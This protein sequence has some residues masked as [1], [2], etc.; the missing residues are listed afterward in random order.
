MLAGQ[1]HVS[2]GRFSDDALVSARISLLPGVYRNWLVGTM[3]SFS[4]RYAVQATIGFTSFGLAFQS[5]RDYRQSRL[6]YS[7]ESYFQQDALEYALVARRYFRSARHP[8]KSWFTDFGVDV[9]DVSLARPSGTFGF[10]NTDPSLDPLKGPG[11]QVTGE[12][13]SLQP[14]RVGIRAGIGREWGLGTHHFLALQLV[15]SFGMSD[16]QQYRMTTL[17]WDLGRNTDPQRYLN[18]VATRVSF[19]GMQARYR[20]QF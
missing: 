19:V 10:G 2:Q 4:P 14:Y 18:Q 12:S 17:T 9:V 20:F 6:A 16:L 7:N 5:Q 15:G 13:T 11:I 8:T 3:L 1:F